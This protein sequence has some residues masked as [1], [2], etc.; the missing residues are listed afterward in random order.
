[1]A[2]TNERGYGL[3]R[4]EGQAIW[5]LGSLMTIKAGSE[6]T[7]GA[8]SL[9]EQLAPPSFEA[10]PH[11]HRQEDEA[12]YVLEGE[13]RV[14]CGQAAW[15]LGPGGF[16]L[17]PRGIPH[18]FS[19]SDAG[20]AKLL[21]ITSPGQFERFASEVGEPARERTL[22]PPAEPDMETLLRVAATY[23]IELA[24]APPTR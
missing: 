8:F 14:T 7:H 17:L 22:P 15:T 18:A 10:P 21:Q 23:N 9:L 1:M 11:I 2:D 4:D 3:Q 19:V 16:V 6:K 13:L 5:F 20:P 12:F 24:A